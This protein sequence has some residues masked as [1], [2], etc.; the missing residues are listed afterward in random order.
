[1]QTLCLS[2]V[3]LSVL[4]QCVLLKLIRVWVSNL[5]SAKFVAGGF[6]LHNKE[7]M[8]RLCCQLTG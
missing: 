6:G 2:S 1:M 4:F 8:S 5:F 7:A 3:S